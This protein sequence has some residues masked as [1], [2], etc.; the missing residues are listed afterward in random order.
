MAVDQ[1][2][3]AEVR[4]PIC[5]WIRGA[6]IVAGVLG[7][8]DSKHSEYDRPATSKKP[9]RITPEVAKGRGAAAEIRLPPEA[10]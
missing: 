7:R 2:I 6:R 9:Q 5:S 10:I 4:R 1:R 3:H 8:A